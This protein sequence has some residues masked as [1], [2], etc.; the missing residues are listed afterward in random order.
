MNEDTKCAALL[1]GL[2]VTGAIL[3]FVL[4]LLGVIILVSVYGAWRKS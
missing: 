2:T 4:P 1:L 3:L